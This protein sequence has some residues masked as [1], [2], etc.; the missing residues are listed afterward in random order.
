MVNQE[1]AQ[2]LMVVYKS[3]EYSQ[4]GR[5]TKKTDVWSFGILILEILTGKVPPNF[6]QKHKGSEEELASWVSSIV[7]EEWTEE[8]FDKEMGPIWGSEGEMLKLLKI[9]L[10]CCEGDVERRC[11]WKEAVG[12]I[13]ELREQDGDEDDGDFSYTS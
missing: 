5:I 10:D 7:P 9:G 13:E 2:Q 8:V 3:P 6:L 11:D 4:L 1:H 12:R